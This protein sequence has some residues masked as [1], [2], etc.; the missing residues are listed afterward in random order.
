MSGSLYELD[1]YGENVVLQWRNLI[2]PAVV[3]GI[4]PLAVISQLMH[5]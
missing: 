1:D 5:Q 3:L 4:R 2:L